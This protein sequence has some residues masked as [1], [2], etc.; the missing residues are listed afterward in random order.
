[1]KTQ[2]YKR[3]SV[4]HY[5]ELPTSQQDFWSDHEDSCFVP[6]PDTDDEWLPLDMFMR[7][8]SNIWH[9][10]YGMTYSSGYFVRLS[11]CGDEA[12]VAYRYS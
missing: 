3:G 6:E 10:V 12:L 1:M 8:N 11:S 2:S 5:T 7:T 9:G 4:I